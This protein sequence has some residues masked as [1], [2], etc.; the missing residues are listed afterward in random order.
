MFPV[1]C[2]E[3]S[4]KKVDFE[5]TPEN[6]KRFLAKRSVYIRT[7]YF[8]F[9]SGDKWAVALV[10]KK[11]ANEVLQE[12]ASIHVLSLPHETAYVEDP[13]LEVLSAS[14][15]GALRERAGTKCVVVKGKAEHV[16]F[17]IDEPPYR[18]T[19]FDVVPPAPSKLV[20]LVQSA[21]ETYL[22]D[23]YVKVDVV[24]VD[25][26]HLAASAKTGAVMFPCRAS[27]LGREGR[28]MFLDETPELTA[29]ELADVTLVG[30]SLSG[31]IFKAIYGAEPTLVNICPRELLKTVHIEGPVIVKCCK[32]REG[33]EVDGKIAIVPWGARAPEVNDALRAV[34]R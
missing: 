20:A 8:V 25:L 15:M 24:E 11:P 13:R 17:F 19:V 28:P 10:V 33:Y 18:L 29:D 27:G 16:S 1:H 12:I 2:K 31:R 5:L 6:I 26:N 34:L 4:V 21:L 30:C 14:A 3:V 7:R 23:K 9:N 22:Q 32:I